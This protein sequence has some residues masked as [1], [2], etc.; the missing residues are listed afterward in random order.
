MAEKVMQD[1]MND[2]DVSPNERT[3][4]LIKGYGVSS[5]KIESGELSECTSGYAR[6]ET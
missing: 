3:F 1:L 6:C 4:V 5:V 2:R